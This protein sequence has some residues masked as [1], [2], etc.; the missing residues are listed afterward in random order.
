[1]AEEVVFIDANVFLEFF[2]DDTHAQEAQSFLE[3]VRDKEVTASTSDFLVYTCLLQI[4]YKLKSTSLMKDFI[5]FIHTLGISLS[6]PSS[7]TILQAIDIMKSDALDF[8][9]SLIVACMMNSGIKTLVSF[10][11]DFDKVSMVQR[12]MPHDF[13]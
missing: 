12:K 1:M 5:L 8:D 13:L 9:D 7:S 4:Q 11:T 3:K 2:L 10:D 6:Q